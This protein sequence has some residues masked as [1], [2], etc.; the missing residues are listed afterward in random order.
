MMRT[1]LPCL[2]LLLACARRG[3]ERVAGAEANDVATQRARLAELDGRWQRAGACPDR[4]SVAQQT[5]DVAQALCAHAE[6]AP[7]RAD[8]RSHCSTG[9]EA[10]AVRT[11]SCRGCDAR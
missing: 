7:D 10:C 3:P 6:R 2:L 5:C 8:L 9:R 11:S 4:C 1:A